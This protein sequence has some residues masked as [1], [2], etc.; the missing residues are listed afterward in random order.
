MTLIFAASVSAVAKAGKTI[1]INASVIKK[2]REVVAKS[3]FLIIL[4]S[5]TLERGNSSHFAFVLFFYLSNSKNDKDKRKKSLNL[6]ASIS[7]FKLF[8]AMNNSD[9]GL[10]TCKMS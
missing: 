2:T 7:M 10:E 6:G 4:T 9:L 1:S 3:H 8:K 5:E